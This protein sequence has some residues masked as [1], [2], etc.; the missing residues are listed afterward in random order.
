MKVLAIIGDLEF[1]IPFGAMVVLWVLG[2]PAW[3]FILIGAGLYIL[4]NV[5]Q[6][7]RGRITLFGTTNPDPPGNPPG[8]PKK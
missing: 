5:F 8:P 7:E 1:I 6:K 3:L 2:Q 4:I